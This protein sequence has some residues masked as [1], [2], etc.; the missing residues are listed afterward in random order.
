MLSS[1]YPV[2]TV[3]LAKTILHEKLGKRRAAGIALAAAAT[4]M[5]N[6]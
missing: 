6:T 4:T 3:L 2:S 5:I 1:L